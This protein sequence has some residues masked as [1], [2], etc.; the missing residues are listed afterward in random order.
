[1][2]E[3]GCAHIR[4]NNNPLA[5]DQR[6]PIRPAGADGAIGAAAIPSSATVTGNNFNGSNPPL[7]ALLVSRRRQ[8]NNRLALTPYRW[9]TFDTD[10]PGAKLS[11][12]IRRFSSLDQKRRRLPLFGFKAR[13]TRPNCIDSVHD[14]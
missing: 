4:P 3:R 12:T 11:A 14:H 7:A 9:A 13:S 2:R 6:N 1:V 8:V 5:A 10:A